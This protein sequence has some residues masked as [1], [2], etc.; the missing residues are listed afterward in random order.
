MQDCPSTILEIAC[1]CNHTHSEYLPLSLSLV[2]ALQHGMAMVLGS[3]SA[4]DFRKMPSSE[5]R[6]KEKKG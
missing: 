2:L 3:V 1:S 5:K 6:K 4:N